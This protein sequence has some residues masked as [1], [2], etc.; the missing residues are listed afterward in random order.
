[1][2]N[3]TDNLANENEPP[4]RVDKTLAWLVDSRNTWKK[5]CMKTKLQLKRQTSAVK[6][7]KDSRD[8][9]KLRHIR[10]KQE[11]IKFE[12]K[13]SSLQR[14]IDELESQVEDQQKEI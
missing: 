12:K 10:L 4:K 13:V 8:E 1:M 3:P 7:V 9:W 11:S 5:K 2:K 6:R 14:R